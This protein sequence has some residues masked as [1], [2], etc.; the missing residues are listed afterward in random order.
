MAKVEE[1]WPA[2]SINPTYFGLLAPYFERPCLR[3]ATPKRIERAT[4]DVI[5]DTG[6]VLHT[7]A[8]NK[9]NRVLL[10]IVPDARDVGCYLHPVCQD[11]HERF[12]A[13]PS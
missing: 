8:A 4:N 12:Y 9:H 3:S 13:G 5:A 7:A 6:K 2:F 10:Q 1:P 11:A